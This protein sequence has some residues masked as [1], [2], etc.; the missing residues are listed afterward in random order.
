MRR[1]VKTM[2]GTALLTVTLITT[3]GAQTQ[4]G[5]PGVAN[6][7]WYA[8][9]PAHLHQ[10]DDSLSLDS[11]AFPIG[12][13]FSR[14]LYHGFECT[15]FLF[16]GATAR[17]V[18]PQR[19][20]AGRPWLWRAR[21]W[22]HAPQTE[23]ALLHRGF[24]VVYCDVAELYG[25]DEAIGRWERFY[26]MLVEAGLCRKPALQ[27]LSRGGIYVYR[28]AA[29]H[30]D[31]VACVYADAPVL[32]VRSW[33]GGKGKSPGN[34]EEWERLKQHF[35]LRSEAEAL[36]FA[37]S[38]IDLIDSIVLGNFP[39]LH[40]CGDADKV[41]PIEENTDRFAPL[42]RAAG[43]EITVIR[44]AGVGHHPHSLED[45]AP[46]VDFILAAVR[47]VCR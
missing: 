10:P 21:F 30:P 31:R 28:W 33:P 25:N 4:E 5:V 11:V 24:H 47:R 36:A 34:P 20:A 1:T 35:G 32:D 38:P 3:L 29:A 16:E 43:G 12:P 15:E 9:E 13:T 23:I 17:I 2:G 18:R 27:G 22:G 40:V 41:V 19:I 44:K 8:Q 42:I 7:P 37:G 39:M 14:S 6:P 45:P 46:I 26:A